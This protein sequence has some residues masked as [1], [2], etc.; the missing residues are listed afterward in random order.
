M[1]ILATRPATP[2]LD[3]LGVLAH[4][5]GPRAVRAGFAAL[6]PRCALQGIATISERPSTRFGTQR[7]SPPKW[8]GRIRHEQESARLA[9][10]D[11]TNGPNSRPRDWCHSPDEALSCWLCTAN[12]AQSANIRVTRSRSAL[13]R[14]I[15]FGGPT[16]GPPAS[17][18]GLPSARASK[19]SDLT[20]SLHIRC[21]RR[22][23][24]IWM[25]SR[26]THAA[27]E[28]AAGRGRACYCLMM[29]R[30]AA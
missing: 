17:G 24:P 22:D 11:R 29:S 30:G 18:Y 21:K 13:A 10:C 5:Q 7:V 8:V 27:H 4:V 25:R 9:S 3:S 2:Q 20:G 19:F 12:A 1:R 16:T 28:V 23:N 6:D 15:L 14:P 26:G